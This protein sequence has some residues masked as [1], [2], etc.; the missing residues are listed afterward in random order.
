M[1]YKMHLVTDELRIGRR[2]D[3]SWDI[4]IMDGDEV[5]DNIILPNDIATDIAEYIFKRS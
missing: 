1:A 2:S 3:G 5:V 4:E